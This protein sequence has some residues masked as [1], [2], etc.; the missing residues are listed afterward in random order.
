MLDSGNPQYRVLVGG[1]EVATVTDLEIEIV[2]EV[3][4]TVHVFER[5]GWQQLTEVQ[6]MV[7]GTR[8]VFTNLL[9]NSLSLMPFDENGLGTRHEVCERMVLNYLKLF[10]KSPVDTKGLL[11]KILLL[12]IDTYLCEIKNI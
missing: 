8:M 1:M 12:S 9:N 4:Y 2:E 3:T 11:P 7:R 10:V 5:Q 6:N